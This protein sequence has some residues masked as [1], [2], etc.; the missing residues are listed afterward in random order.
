MAPVITAVFVIY[1]ATRAGGGHG[2]TTQGAVERQQGHGHGAGQCDTGLGQEGATTRVL[3]S[4]A[5]TGFGSLV[6][7][8]EQAIK[9]L[10]HDLD[11]R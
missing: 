2:H 6:D 5:G 1:I 3:G 8:S 10:G 11:S 7:D 4:L 9:E